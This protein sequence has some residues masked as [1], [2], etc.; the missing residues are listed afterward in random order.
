MKYYKSV[1]D[2]VEEYR[3]KKGIVRL[4]TDSSVYTAG[5]VL[6]ILSFSWLI[7]FQLIYILGGLLMLSSD[8]LADNATQ[9]LIALG[10]LTPISAIGL[11]LLCLKQHIASL[12]VTVLS[13][14]LTM[15]VF[16]QNEQVQLSFVSGIF[17]SPFFWRHFAPAIL[18]IIFAALA[19]GIGIKTALDLK[20]D[21]KKVMES[22]F[23]NF[24]EKFP[25]ASDS[26]WQ[27]Y[28]SEGAVEEQ[29][30]ANP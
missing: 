27:T 30:N 12:S 18:L 9:L 2:R 6:Y 11:V 7:L 5:K 29:D 3:Y 15:A 14:V 4:N 26:Q 23:I 21:Y 28:L 22:M 24:K 20:K 19:C 1:L 17:T 16:Y 8:R 10:I 13:A 25:E